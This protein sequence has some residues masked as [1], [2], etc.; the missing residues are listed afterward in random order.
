MKKIL[1]LSAMFFLVLG[2]VSSFAQNE[3]KEISPEE[4]A[5]KETKNLVKKLNLTESQE[6]Y[7]DSILTSNYVGVMN[8]IMDMKRSGMQD[9]ENYRRVSEQWKEKNLAA[10]KLVLDEQQYI[11]YLRHIGRGKEY[12]KGKDGKWYLK[13]DLKKKSKNSQ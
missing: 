2:T 6:F 12:K 4:M 8:A 5:Q 1:I 9:P 11:T 10:M 7:V 3:E 13:S